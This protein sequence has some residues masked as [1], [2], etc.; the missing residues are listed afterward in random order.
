MHPGNDYLAEAEE[1]V[2]NTIGHIG[3]KS[4]NEIFLLPT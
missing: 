1:G 2:G 3:G 4:D